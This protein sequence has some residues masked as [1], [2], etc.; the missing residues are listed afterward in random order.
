MDR[1]VDNARLRLYRVW[2]S[3]SLA[4]AA[5]IVKSRPFRRAM[6]LFVALPFIIA[7]IIVSTRG[8]DLGANHMPIGLSPRYAA[9]ASRN[10][11]GDQADWAN[12]KGKYSSLPDD[13]F[14]IAMLTYR[15]PKELNETLTTLLSEKIPSLYELVV[16]WGDIEDKA[17]PADFVSKYGVPVRYRMAEENSLNEKLRP[18]PSFKTQAVLLTDDD[19][20]YSPSDLEFVFQTWRQFGQNRLTGALARCSTLDIYGDYHYTFCNK[21]AENVYSMVLTNLCFSHISFMD[22][23]W[24]NNTVMNEVRA[25]VDEGMNCEDIALNYVQGLLT[26]H[27]PLLVNGDK[28]YVNMDP[29]T[30]ISRNPGHLEA[31][32]KCLNDFAKMFDCMPLVDESAHIQKGIL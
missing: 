5:I 30:G 24:S 18:D 23:Y 6:T 19:V 8:V 32:S 7:L 1:F 27:G 13:K 10:E 22:Y 31:R 9:C 28:K 4:K 12:M 16:V 29:G 2:H 20:Y 3:P 17:M 26:G 25:Y 21:E 14:T 11:S 15:R